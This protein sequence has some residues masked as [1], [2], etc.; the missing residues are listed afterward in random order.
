MKTF[1]LAAGKGTRLRPLTDQ[2][3]KC[4]VPI[5]GKPL[6]QIWLELLGRH[7]IEE[8]LVN[9]HH[10]A[11]QVEAFVKQRVNSYSLLVNGE[12]KDRRKDEHRTSNVQ[13]RMM[14]GKKK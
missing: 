6:L 10:H 4:L 14:N 7:G 8:V 3:P 1:L 13:H 2:I 11:E 9:T 12:R 5:N